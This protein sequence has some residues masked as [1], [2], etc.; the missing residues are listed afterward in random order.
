[1]SGVYLA[2]LHTARGVGREQWPCSTLRPRP[3]P[4]RIQLHCI[5]YAAR[6]RRCAA[7]GAAAA[8]RRAAA[9]A[10]ARVV[11]GGGSIDLL[12]ALALPLPAPLSGSTDPRTLPAAFLVIQ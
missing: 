11:G 2:L 4:R 8:R 5:L 6:V 9:R 1:M 7:A 3:P 12:C 10:R